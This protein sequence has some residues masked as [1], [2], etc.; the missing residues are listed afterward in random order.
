M[1]ISD[2][3]HIHRLLLRLLDQRVPLLGCGRQRELR[4]SAKR[5]LRVIWS[6]CS[7]LAHKVRSSS[8]PPRPKLY[9]AKSLGSYGSGCWLEPKRRLLYT[10]G[11][12]EQ[13]ARIQQDEES[14]NHKIIK[15]LQR[16]CSN[17]GNQQRTNEWRPGGIYSRESSEGIPENSN[18]CRRPRKGANACERKEGFRC[19]WHVKFL[20]LVWS[21]PWI[22]Q[23]QS[24]ILYQW[25][26]FRCITQSL[27]WISCHDHA[28]PLPGLFVEHP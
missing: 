1:L 6:F 4:V 18:G 24:K 23:S 11:T 3:G 16:V 2:S 26:R 12:T 13:K 22:S 9:V 7:L 14:T 25:G 19:L 27:I 5:Q 28:E 8:E 17:S 15:R 21:E 20:L 10:E